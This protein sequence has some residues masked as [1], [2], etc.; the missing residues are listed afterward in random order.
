MFII[1]SDALQVLWQSFIV[2]P[3]VT[4]F[5]F[6]DPTA[7]KITF[8][9]LSHTVYCRVSDSQSL[10][11]L[12]AGKTE[13]LPLSLSLKGALRLLDTD[14]KYQSSARIATRRTELMIKKQEQYVDVLC[15]VCSVVFFPCQHT[16]KM[17][18]QCFI[19][20]FSIPLSL[21]VT[22]H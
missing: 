21:T 5:P 9:L 12:K 4:L 10:H 22:H 3:L 18:S 13:R 7:H 1:L 17:V 15:F 2:T 11:Y 20:Y 8:Q 16:S 14:K 19:L 6:F